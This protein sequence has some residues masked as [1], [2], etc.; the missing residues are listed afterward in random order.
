M[1]E[2]GFSGWGIDLDETEPGGG[3]DNVAPFITYSIPPPV[4]TGL[5]PLVVTITDNLG[6]LG[7][8]IV[9]VEMPDYGIHEVVWDGTRQT[10]RYTG[11]G[12]QRTIVDGGFQLAFLRAGGWIGGLVR[13]TTVA[14][15]LDGNRRT[16]VASVQIGESATQDELDAA[17]EAAA[18]PGRVF[19]VDATT[20]DMVRE[21]GRF[22]RIGGVESIAQAVRSRLRLL[23]G[24]YFID[25]QEGVPYWEQILVKNPSLS[26]V[27]EIFRRTIVGTPG[28][29]EVLQLDLTLSTER[30]LRVTARCDTDLGEITV[31][32]ELGE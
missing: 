15:D 24:D 31:S 4:V 28:V 13:V 20:G 25:P 18:E 9:M 2:F 27:R 19:K 7:V 14:V 26:A 1:S 10:S 8:A 11:P 16:T 6:E 21:G 29:D 12:N 22:V 32:E 23:L 30:H 5:D 3:G 17:E